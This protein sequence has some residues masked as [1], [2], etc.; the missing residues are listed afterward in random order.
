MRNS[1]FPS[2]INSILLGLYMMMTLGVS[3]VLL[4]RYVA[5]FQIGLY[6]YPFVLLLVYRL[7]LTLLGLIIFTGGVFFCMLKGIV[8]LPL[9]FVLTAAIVAQFVLSRKF[10]LLS[11]YIIY[12]LIGLVFVNAAIHDSLEILM[13]SSRNYVSIKLLF[14]STLITIITYRQNDKI[15]IWPALFTLVLS[16]LAIGRGGILCS[17]I[18]F[19]GL[20]YLK[21]VK[22]MNVSLKIGFIAVLCFIALYN[23]SEIEESY[24]A[25]EQLE[26]IRDKGLEDSARDRIW[27]E[28]FSKI[29]LLTFITGCNLYECRIIHSFDNNPHNS[30]ILM[31]AYLG[32]FAFIPF[33]LMLRALFVNIRRKDFVYVLP[34][35]ALLIRCFTDKALLSYYDFI[36]MIFIYRSFELES[37]NVLVSQCLNQAKE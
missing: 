31:H 3:L 12:G 7:R 5:I 37:E 9:V 2:V 35:I 20:V 33:W 10:N 6:L 27:A 18:N 19:F 14:L 17:S 21:Y 8:Y 22:G 34:L 29:D 36:I 26:R 11:L 28:Y 4:D 13:T 1:D 25:S 23:W 24:E 32:V 15:I 30:Y 16:L